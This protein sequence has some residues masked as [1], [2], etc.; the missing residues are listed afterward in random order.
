M[1]IITTVLKSGGEF[2]P[3]HVQRLHGQFGPLPSVCL[4]DIPVSGVNVLPLCYNWP[5]W[6][7]KMEL[8]NPALIQD[9]ILYFDLDTLL[10]QSPEKYLHDNCLRMLSDFYSPQRPASGMMFIPHASKA[11]IWSRWMAASEAWMRQCHG[12]QDVLMGICGRHIARFGRQVKSY[13]VHVATRGM[14]G[15]HSRRSRGSGTIP[16]DTDVLCF[17]GFP[18]PWSPELL[19]TGFGETILNPQYANVDAVSPPRAAIVRRA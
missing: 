17:H 2:T 6:F 11:Q 10:I 19:Q 4:S 18:R 7:S 15:Y 5:G 8:F 3:E 16:P 13:K 12:D 14:P 9:D 1:T